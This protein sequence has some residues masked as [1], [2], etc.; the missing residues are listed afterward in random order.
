MIEELKL[1][2]PVLATLT[3]GAYWGVALYFVHSFLST[4]L[5]YGLSVTF[6]VLV[7]RL[8]KTVYVRTHPE[9]YPTALIAAHEAMRHAWLYDTRARIGD[10]S[11]LYKMHEEL[12]A[13]VK[14]RKQA[15]NTSE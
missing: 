9:R 5:G 3:D 7:Y 6:L 12:E 11:K 10:A 8:L 14:A 15:E 4:L 2:L 13:M 1:L